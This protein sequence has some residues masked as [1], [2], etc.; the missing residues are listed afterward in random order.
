MEQRIRINGDGVA[1]C[2]SQRCQACFIRFDRQCARWVAERRSQRVA[3]K[4]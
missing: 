1:N 4:S 3:M 2:V